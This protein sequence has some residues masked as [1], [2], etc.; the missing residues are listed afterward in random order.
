[1]RS[2]RIHWGRI[3]VGGLLAEVALILAIV[4]LGLRLGDNFLHHTAP[5]G[6]FV[7]CFLSGDAGIQRS[8][9]DHHAPLSSC[10]SQRIAPAD[11][12]E[13]LTGGG[14]HAG[15]R[16]VGS[17]AQHMLINGASGRAFQG[18]SN[19]QLRGSVGNTAHGWELILQLTFRAA[20]V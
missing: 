12:P 2:T 10:K 7:T 1:M 4:P 16:T 13:V 9:A 17:I 6:S 18:Q 20:K 15:Y 8:W 14:R 19:Q 3:V 11:L 5:P